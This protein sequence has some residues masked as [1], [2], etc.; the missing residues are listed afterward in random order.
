MGSIKKYVLISVCDD[1]HL[2]LYQD[3]YFQSTRCDLILYYKWTLMWKLGWDVQQVLL[4]DSV[5][6]SDQ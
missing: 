6:F 2:R 4:I 5:V 3:D 1:K